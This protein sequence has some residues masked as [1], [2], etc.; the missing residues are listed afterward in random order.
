M[1]YLVHRSADSSG[2]FEPVDHGGNDV[3]AVPH[4][5]Y[6]DTSGE[7][8][9]DQWYAVAALSEVTRVGP[10]S[11]PVVA[12]AGR[13]GRRHGHGH[14]RGG[15]CGRPAGATVAADDR[16]RAPEPDALRGPG[17]RPD[18]RPGAA[19]SV[20]PDARRARR[21]D[22]AGARDPVRRP[23]RLPRAGRRAGARLQ[24]GRPGL[25]HLARARAAPCR[26]AVLHAARPGG[27][28]DED[29]VRLRR[30]HL[31]A[32]RLG[33][34]GRPGD[35]P[36]GAPGRPLRAGRGARPVELRGLERGEPRRLLE[37]LGGGVPPAV[38]RHG[39]R[40][41]QGRRAAGRRRTELGCGAVGRVAAGARG[42]VRG[43]GRLRVDAHLRQ[44]A[45]GPAADPGPARS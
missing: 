43:T 13:R 29:G 21:R 18:H 8:D 33:P 35:R 10:L 9:T 36:D 26:R 4:P 7:R 6:V 23:R 37:R 12:A 44:P 40:R 22:G 39:R 1:G 15:P 41:A 14:R 28:P 31:A 20:A 27:G 2:G 19:G 38:R 16:L 30:H 17:R 34:L 42:G 3:L 5:P 32:A 45:A 24:R 25:R 11:D